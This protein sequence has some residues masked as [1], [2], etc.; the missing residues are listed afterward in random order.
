MN[1]GLF[2]VYSRAII[3]HTFKI[4]N[5]PAKSYPVVG[6]LDHLVQGKYVEIQ[7]NAKS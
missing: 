4:I 6:Q 1:V 7:V 5:L 3:K 2:C